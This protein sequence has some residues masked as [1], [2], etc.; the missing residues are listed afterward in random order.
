MYAFRSRRQRISG[1]VAPFP[2]AGAVGEFLALVHESVRDMVA[3]EGCGALQESLN[4]ACLEARAGMLHIFTH[5]ELSANGVVSHGSGLI[6]P[7]FTG[8]VVTH[9]L[10]G[11]ESRQAERECSGPVAAVIDG[12]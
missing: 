1:A 6:E 8:Y 5:S 7:V 12:E 9:E 11:E 2:F 3:A 4:H 10:V